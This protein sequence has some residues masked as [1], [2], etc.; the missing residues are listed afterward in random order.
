MTDTP[1][2]PVDF[3]RLDKHQR[4]V[5]QFSGGKDSLALLY[6]FRSHLGRITVFHCDTSDQLPEMQRLVNVVEGSVPAFHR[7]K[8]DAPAWIAK[9]GLPSDLVPVRC[10]PVV[11]TVHRHAGQPI[12]PYTDCCAANRWRPMDEALRELRPSLVIHGQR[13]G[14]AFGWDKAADS[15]TATMPGGW[16][17]WAPIADWS[18]AQVMDYLR[19]AGAPILPWYTHQPHAPECA[20]CPASWGEQRAAYLQKHHPDLAAKYAAALRIHAR[21]T[22]PVVDQF[23]AE[24]RALGLGE[25]PPGPQPVSGS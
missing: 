5:L 23:L 15:D 25:I 14:D 8:S 6:L 13:R 24:W 16:Q 11:A 9:H 22:R 18:D 2:P 20:T 17:S 19:E 21:E 10:H 4:I 12:V 3:G 1:R 7:V